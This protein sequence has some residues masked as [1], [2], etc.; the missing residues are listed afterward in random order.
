MKTD[1]PIR[2]FFVCGD[3]D[4][5][6]TESF[7][8]MHRMGIDITVM[9]WP[10]TA[11]YE[12]L[13]AAGIPTIPHVLK[14]KLS[15]PCI[16]RIRAEL[17]RRKYD[18]LHMLDKR[19]T[20]NGLMASIGIDVK[21]VAY[22]GIIGN[23]AYWSP[24]SWL[25]LLNPRLDRIICVCEAIRQYLLGLG[26][27]GLRLRRD[28]PVT[29]HKGHRPELYEGEAEDLQQFGIPDDTFV[30]ACTVRAVPRKGVPVF[31]EAIGKLPPGLNIHFLLAG[32]KMDSNQH[33]NLVTNS[34][35]ADNIHLFGWLRR[36]PW[37]LK[38]VDVSVLP[39]LSREG[40]PRAMLEAM[41]AGVVP[42]VTDVGGNPELVVDD[43]SGFV[44]EP[45]DAQA[46]RDR[47]LRLYNDRELLKR[48]SEAARQRVLTDFT[49][50]KTARETVA[51]YNDLLGRED[52][53]LS[54]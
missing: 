3:S 39:S 38:N 33:R 42:I 5:A 34:P 35:Y 36:M 13:I 10:G 44:V 49:V 29:I 8:E 11:S 48:M 24:Q 47:I 54:R 2:V 14:W 21:L 52:P 40:L 46:I 26:M 51:V 53:A 16:R 6:E 7:I 45:G 17:K 50:E 32:P 18:V 25:Y 12:A 15:P 4:R 30:V 23:L 28:V 43:V 22:R 31:V 37:I 41:I 27:P 9:T 19:A 20:M 1:G